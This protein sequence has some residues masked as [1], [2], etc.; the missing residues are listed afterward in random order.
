M[1]MSEYKRLEQKERA[2][3]QRYGKDVEVYLWKE[4]TNVYHIKIVS[5]KEYILTEHLDKGTPLYTTL[6]Y[7]GKLR[8]YPVY[9]HAEIQVA[10]DIGGTE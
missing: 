3:K 1:R 4:N 10:D 6:E 9:L 7:D 8:K 2:F 5:G